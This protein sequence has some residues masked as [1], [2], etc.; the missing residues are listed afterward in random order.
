MN[1]CHWLLGLPYP[2]N[3][4]PGYSIGSLSGTRRQ[5]F[6][7]DSP[8]DVCLSMLPEIR[9]REVTTHQLILVVRL[10]RH[11][12]IRYEFYAAAQLQMMI[13]TEIVSFS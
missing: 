11:F 2:G 5:I 10:Y 4:L 6:N 12:S 13:K 3:L 1:F 7:G 8:V 9:S